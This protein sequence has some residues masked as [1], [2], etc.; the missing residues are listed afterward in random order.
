MK[1]RKIRAKLH[2]FFSWLISYVAFVVF[3]LSL[4]CMDSNSW[5]PPVAL[6]V[7]LAWLMIF[8]LAYEDR[9]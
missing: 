7:S 9:W 3:L 6:I 4:A 2:N 8:A 5:I 1:K